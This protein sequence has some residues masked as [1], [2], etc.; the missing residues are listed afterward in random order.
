MTA[1]EE[2]NSPPNDEP[3]I[4]AEDVQDT[5]TTD[6]DPTNFVTEAFPAVTP[7][8]ESAAREEA[9][10]NKAY[11]RANFLQYLP[12]DASQQQ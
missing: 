12:F 10:T 2:G 4:A 7:E 1:L 9:E 8:F 11:D 6:S 5:L 3:H